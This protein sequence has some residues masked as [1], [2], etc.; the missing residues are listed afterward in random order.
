MKNIFLI[1]FMGC[2][3]STVASYMAQNY[4][5]E[6][7]EMDQLIVER[8][9]MS[10]PEIF[11]KHGEEYFRTVETNL[12]IEIQSL[13]NK[14]VSCGGGVVLREQNVAEMK[15][16]GRIVLLTAKPETILER[17]KDDDNRPLL[18]GNKNVAFISGM[19]EKRRPKY[20]AAADVVIQTDGKSAEEICKE[21]LK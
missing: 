12:L 18:R 9:G 4:G 21:I 11:E 14:V 17:V 8:E 13:E 1:G 6:V 2:G 5:M 10:I 20:E 15:K 19:M 3:K 16:S 7:M